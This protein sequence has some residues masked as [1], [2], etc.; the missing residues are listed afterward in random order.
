GAGSSRAERESARGGTR[1]LD[2]VLDRTR[3]QRGVDQQ[4][5]GRPG[6]LHD[7]DKI[8]ERIVRESPVQGDVGR[9]G[10]GGGGHERIAVGRRM[11]D[12]DR[13]GDRTR[14]RPVL[15]HERLAIEPFELAADQPGKDAVHATGRGRRNDGDGAVRIILRP[16]VRSG[17]QDKTDEG[18]YRA[19][20]ALPERERSHDVYEYAAQYCR[21]SPHRTTP[22]A[23]A[24]IRIAA[25][26]RS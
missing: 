26:V 1:Q 9:H 12:E 18:A 13:A 7:R 20:W 16:R 8:G 6:N 19:P 10:R 5:L 15:D 3:R 22:R 21:T 25:D 23:H 4:N 11:R 14:T 17:E 24:R 2:Q